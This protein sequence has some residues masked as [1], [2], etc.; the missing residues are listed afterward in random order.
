M[1]MAFAFALVFMILLSGCTG[2]QSAAQNTSVPASGSQAPSTSQAPNTTPVEN[3][4][5]GGNA[6]PAGSAPASPDNQTVIVQA[7]SPPVPAGPTQ[8][9]SVTMNGYAFNPANITVQKGTTVQLTLTSQDRTYGFAIVGY[10]VDEVV[11]AGKPSVVTFTADKPGTFEIKDS[12]VTSGA[13][14]GMVGT[15]TVTG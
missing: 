15:L 11:P 7:S 8:S 3:S 5:M 13:A 14:Y 9:I 12:Y 10:P 2:Q 1:K 4:T 6:S